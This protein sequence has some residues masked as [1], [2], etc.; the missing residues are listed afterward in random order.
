MSLSIV[1][2][3]ALGQLGS[4][5]RELASQYPYHFVF[6]D[7]DELD[8]TTP[9]QVKEFFVQHRFR[10]CI[11]CAS[12]TAVDKAESE[13]EQAFSVNAESVRNLVAACCEVDAQLLHVSTD[14]V[15]DGM[16]SSPY[17]EDDETH[18]LSVYG[19]SKLAGEGEALK[20]PKSFIV[21]TAWLYSSFGK[22]FVKTI[23]RL[24]SERKEI[25]V[26][27]E[28]VGTPTYAR[29]LA[30]ALLAM[31]AYSEAHSYTL[32]DLYGLYHYS[33]EGV[34]SWYDF[35][36][37]IVDAAGSLCLIKPI[38]VKDYPTPA[39]RPFYSV[40]NKGK[41]KKTFDISIPHWRKSLEECMKLLL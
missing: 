30:R 16:K 33:N 29:D 19:A 39:R 11:N 9:K 35:A 24:A 38:E 14:F 10:W 5:I 8:V 1:V 25:G 23:L 31:I 21:R 13:R 27:F 22:N 12:Y 40:L 15:F 26:I 32:S 36:Q 17:T 2:T 3:G 34:A 6:T 41:I 28:Q 18:A 4:E 37:A 20:Y 7:R